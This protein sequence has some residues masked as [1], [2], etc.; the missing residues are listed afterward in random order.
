MPCFDVG[1]SFCEALFLDMRSVGCSA[2]GFVWQV[3][4]S[5]TLS[6]RFVSSGGGIRKALTPEGPDA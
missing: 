6:K 4:Q 2:G 1:A 5:T 3:E